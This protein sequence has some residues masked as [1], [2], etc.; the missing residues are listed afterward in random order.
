MEST[1]IVD[2]SVGYFLGQLRIV[3]L[4]CAVGLALISTLGAVLGGWLILLGLGV[5]TNSTDSPVGLLGL[6]ALVVA[7]VVLLL[8][9]V[10][11]RRVWPLAGQSATQTAATLVAVYAIGSA[12][13]VAAWTRC[14]SGTSADRAGPPLLVGL[15]LAALV[16][17]GIARPVEFLAGAVVG[18]A[19]VAL[20]VFWWLT[21]NT[22]AAGC[23]WHE[24]P[25]VR[26]P[27][28]PT[29]TTTVTVGP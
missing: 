9:V 18:L 15:C 22:T 25:P 29:T 16:T 14:S 20:V 12:I 7:A 5:G 26:M 24:P 21:S 17:A 23:P 1:R 27:P 11:A 13:A 19:S 4:V 3:G 10:A 8:A 28:A 2:R 6:M